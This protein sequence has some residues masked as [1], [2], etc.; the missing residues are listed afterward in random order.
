MGAAILDRKSWGPPSWIGSRDVID[1]KV[2]PILLIVG[3]RVVR[4]QLQLLERWPCYIRLAGRVKFASL[5]ADLCV[6][7]G[8]GVGAFSLFH[9]FHSGRSPNMTEILL[10]GTVNLISIFAVSY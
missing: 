6:C 7:V 2:A 4:S 8:G 3:G 1:S 10:S 5:E 9:S